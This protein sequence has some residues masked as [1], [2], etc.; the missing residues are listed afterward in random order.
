[1]KKVLSVVFVVVAVLLVLQVAVPSQ[2]PSASTPVGAVAADVAPSQ[3]PK[4][5]AQIQSEAWTLANQIQAAAGRKT[6]PA[7]DGSGVT[8]VNQTRVDTTDADFNAGT[9]NMTQATNDQLHTLSGDPFEGT[10]VAAIWHAVTPA[11]NVVWAEGGGILTSRTGVDN[12]NSIQYVDITGQST[13][14]TTVNVT[15]TGLGNGWNIANITVWNAA[16]TTLPSVTTAKVGVIFVRSPAAT[17]SGYPWYVDTGGG[18]HWWSGTAWGTTKVAL[19]LYTTPDKYALV[20]IEKDATNYKFFGKVASTGKF[21]ASIAISSVRSGSGS[22][23]YSVGQTNGAVDS[24]SANTNWDNWTINPGFPSGTFDSRAISF[25][26]WSALAVKAVWDI[27]GSPMFQYRHANNSDMSGAS[28]WTAATN[29]TDLTSQN[30]RA[31]FWQYRATFSS[32]AQVLYDFTW[33]IKSASYGSAPSKTVLSYITQDSA[34]NGQNLPL[35]GRTIYVNL[36]VTSGS[37]TRIVWV[38]NSLLDFGSNASASFFFT[39]SASVPISFGTMIWKFYFAN[40]TFQH[41]NSFVTFLISFSEPIVKAYMF[42]DNVTITDFNQIP[43]PN[44]GG[45]FGTNWDYC[46]IGVHDSTVSSWNVANASVSA[47]QGTTNAVQGGLLYVNRTKGTN[48]AGV[49]TGYLAYNVRFASWNWIIGGFGGIG[50]EGA[51]STT[52]TQRTEWV[53]Y[54]HNYINGNIHTALGLA[55]TPTSNYYGT[56]FGKNAYATFYKNVIANGTYIQ[57][58]TSGGMRNLTVLNNY[59]TGPNAAFDEAI[60]LNWRTTNS[61]ILYNYFWNL[62]NTGNSGIVVT[63]FAE[64]LLIQGNVLYDVGVTALSFGGL[65]KKF[66]N[67]AS[68]YSWRGMNITSKDNWAEGEWWSTSRGWKQDSGTVSS[69]N[70][71]IISANC[72]GRP[73]VQVLDGWNDP[74][75]GTGSYARVV[76]NDTSGL[77]L[78]QKSSCVQVSY[79]NPVNAAKVEILILR[80][81]SLRAGPTSGASVTVTILDSTNSGE[82]GR[83]GDVTSATFTGVQTRWIWAPYNWI[84]A[85]KWLT[86]GPQFDVSGATLYGGTITGGTNLQFTSATISGTLVLQGAYVGDS[87]HSIAFSIST[88]AYATLSSWNLWVPSGPNIDFPIALSQATGT[89]TVT[90]T[91]ISQSVG[92]YKDGVYVSLAVTSGNSQ[93]MTVPGPWSTHEITITSPPPPG[94]GGGGGGGGNPPTADVITAPSSDGYTYTFSVTPPTGYDITSASWNFGD[95]ST[96]TGTQVTHTFAN[97]GIYVVTVKVTYTTGYSAPTTTNVVVVGPASSIPDYVPLLIVLAA[98]VALVL[99]FASETENRKIWLS[100]IALGIFWG[101]VAYIAVGQFPSLIPRNVFAYFPLAVG[102]V[103]GLMAIEKQ[104][105]KKL[106]WIVLVIAAVVVWSITL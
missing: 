43:G 17:G 38:N 55:G 90:V 56:A 67:G 13:Y 47:F 85:T 42:F 41:F 82:W 21:A 60:G 34:W 33:N 27:A 91:G 64:N 62:N 24:G 61:S 10:S 75:P 16:P 7:N 81:S 32:A 26:E 95:G 84:N 105:K 3:A 106:A 22:D 68:D 59:F 63:D 23:F 86:L 40:D 103:A 79:A 9:F 71:T 83:Y 98:V 104:N 1:M 12:A 37:Q 46:L 66:S 50:W 11:S 30:L 19:N 73:Q 78:A 77:L 15:G 25:S 70:D 20:A 18:Y 8:Q 100:L 5:R 102:A 29:N 48:K 54:S 4:T 35:S 44:G 101:A 31:A 80:G 57:L 88:G 49:T 76:F 14:N 28:A 92:V 51:S 74:T 65:G 53:N 69:F 96:A 2:A 36:S 52:L 94:G 72:I 45:C 97:L 87:L 93:T 58:Q 6:N 89:L 99:V 39:V